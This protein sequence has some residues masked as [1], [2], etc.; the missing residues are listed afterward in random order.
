ML[1]LL[2]LYCA[3]TV[4]AKWMLAA[5]T[6]RFA[7]MVLELYTAIT[8]CATVLRAMLFAQPDLDMTLRYLSLFRALPTALRT[9]WYNPPRPSW[10]LAK[11]PHSL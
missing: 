6:H 1:T 10:F 3:P 7:N 4:V 2:L 9:S 5:I 11:P 8:L